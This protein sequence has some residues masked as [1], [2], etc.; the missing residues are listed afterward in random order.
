MKVYDCFIFSSELE[1]L[2]L[3]L[4]FLNDTVDHF[5]IVESSQTLSGSDKKLFYKE[6]IERYKKYNEK[7]IYLECP[8]KPEMGAWEY[9]FFQRDYLREGLKKCDDN[10]IIFISD[11]DEIVN[12]S[13]I[14]KYGKLRTPVLIGLP[15][16]NYFFN[17]KSDY[18]MLQNLMAPYSFIKTFNIGQRLP[19]FP[20]QIN[21]ILTEK[22]LNVGWH[23]SYLFGFD[24]E[25]YVEKVRS[26]SH[27][28]YNTS[29]YL[30]SKRILK[31]ITL[32][33]DLFERGAVTF[34]F[35]DE[36]A[37]LSDILPAIKQLN[38]NQYLHTP[39]KKDYSIKAL[40]FLFRKKSIPV[41][42]YKYSLFLKRFFYPTLL[43]IWRKGRNLIK[44]KR[45]T[46]AAKS[47]K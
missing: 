14:L 31:C 15:T 29:Y 42:R 5:V 32:G 11:V 35:Q 33:V 37:V 20:Q 6:N 45:N 3:R 16:Y 21:N 23:F 47:I 43:P 46:R 34:K 12:I 30:N 17:L 40:W 4:A 36:N 19:N 18:A 44:K 1:L 27:Q 26:F 38:L 24:I 13:E 10:D 2:D 28:E 22:D 8:Q 25:K 7:I 39:L 9:E 41:I